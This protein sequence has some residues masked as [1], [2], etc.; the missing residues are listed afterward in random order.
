MDRVLCHHAPTPSIKG[1]Y[2]RNV[3]QCDKTLLFL[4]HDQKNQ[5]KQEVIDCDIIKVMLPSCHLALVSH[6]LLL[7]RSRLTL[8]AFSLTLL[9]ITII[10]IVEY[11]S[12]PINMLSAGGCN[13]NHN[14][15]DFTPI[16]GVIKLCPCLLWMHGKKNIL[17]LL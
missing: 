17:C 4:S 9:H 10:I 3:F 15:Y 16:H 13:E 12:S 6:Q 5:K 1:H 7:Q 14:S 2:I 8:T 11:F